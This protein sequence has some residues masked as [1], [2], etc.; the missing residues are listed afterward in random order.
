MI[1]DRDVAKPDRKLA[2]PDA[3]MKSREGK[4]TLSEEE[5]SR[6]SGGVCATGQ[7]LK[8]ATLIAR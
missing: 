3:E 6:V 5:L 8:E 1:Q 2:T 4:M 7:H